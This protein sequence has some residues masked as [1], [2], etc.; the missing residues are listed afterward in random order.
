MSTNIS[1]SLFDYI[2]YLVYQVYYAFLNSV[3]IA[4]F[5]IVMTFW[6]VQGAQVYTESD[7]V[8]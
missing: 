2:M 6:M 7:L 4:F 5:F 3:Y 1:L 8:S